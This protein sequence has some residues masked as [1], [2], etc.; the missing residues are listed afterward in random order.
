MS[1][2][3]PFFINEKVIYCV[4]SYRQ[5]DSCSAT[6]HS[7]KLLFAVIFSFNCEQREQLQVYLA[8]V[9]KRTTIPIYSPG[10]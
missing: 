3:H 6:L 4:N 2:A 8:T 5:A 9:R 7:C 10:R 1:D